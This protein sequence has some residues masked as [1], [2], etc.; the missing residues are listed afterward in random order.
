V[1]GRTGSYLPDYL[2]AAMALGGGS[3]RD[4]FAFGRGVGIGAFAGRGLTQSRNFTGIWMARGARGHSCDEDAKKKW[5][6]GPPLEK[7]GVLPELRH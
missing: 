1:V 4:I 5:Q 7:S 2:K 3:V 6:S